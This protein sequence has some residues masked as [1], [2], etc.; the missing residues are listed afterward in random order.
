MHCD[1]VHTD[2]TVTFVSMMTS[3]FILKG[4]VFGDQSMRGV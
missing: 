3:V 4:L 1:G 2:A